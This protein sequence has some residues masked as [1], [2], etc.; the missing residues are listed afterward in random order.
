[1]NLEK[2]YPNQVFTA[3]IWGA[4]RRAFDYAP[5]TLSGRKICVSGEI[6]TYKGVAE[7]IVSTPKQTQIPINDGTHLD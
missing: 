5:E 3:V 4:G 1:L 6:P 2:P 7:I